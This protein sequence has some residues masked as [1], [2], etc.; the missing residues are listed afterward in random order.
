M[1][2]QKRPA[3]LCLND[4]ETAL[5]IRELVLESKGYDVISTTHAQEAL[6]LVGSR[7]IDL[8]IADHLLRDSVGTDVAA[9][10]KQLRPRLPVILLSGVV[11]KPEDMQNV[12]AFVH[13]TEG[14]EALLNAIDKFLGSRPKESAG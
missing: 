11:E 8:V 2:E 14:P 10:I 9:E 5:M 3:I 7:P 1:T 13:K 4:D 6:E 12:D